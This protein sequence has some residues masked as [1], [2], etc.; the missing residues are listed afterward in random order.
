M[1]KTIQARYTAT[2]VGAVA[3]IA[4]LTAAGIELWVTPSLTATD[5]RSLTGAAAR[6]GDV[7][8]TELARVQAQQRV[9]TETVPQLESA[10]IDRLLP[11][12]VNQYGELKVFGGGIWPLPNKRE[13]G[14]AKFSTF[15][16][17][18][19][20]GKLIVNTHW[21]SPESKNYFEQSWYLGG[22]K[23]PAGQCNWANAYQDD[24]S[25]EP[26]T[27]CAMAISKNGEPYGVATID[28]TLGFFNDL[29]AKKEAELHARLLIVESDGTVL[30]NEPE[31][32]GNNVLKNL[33]SLAGQYPFAA[34][35]QSAL[36]GGLSRDH[37][38]GV[39][40]SDYTLFIQ[41][42]EGTPWQLVVAQ[43]THLLTQQSSKV[44]S[45]LAA[46]Q[47]PLVLVLLAL[48][49]LALRSLIK[50]LRVL[51]QNIDTLSAGDADLT[52]RI[53]IRAD[54]ELGAVGESVNRFIGYLQNMMKEVAQSSVLI[55]QGID[56]LRQQA[57][58][59]NQI[60]TRHANETDQA[61]TAITEMTSTAEDVARNAAQTA[62]MT[63]TA[64]E[65]ARQSKRVVDDASSSVQALI[66]EV[67]AATA[68]VRSM[69]E[70]AQ[71]INAVLGVIGEI[72]G[73]TNLLALNAAIEAA[74]AGEQG[75]GFAVVADEVRALAGRT[76]TSTSEINDMLSRLQQGVEAAVV[77]ME[78]TKQSCQATVDKTARVNQG[79]DGMA[80]SVVQINDLS[81][82]IAT[83]AEEQS[84]VS[85]EINRNMVAVRHMVEELVAGGAQGEQSTAAL[86]ASNERLIAV[87]Q[88]FKLG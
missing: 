28:V 43:Q 50:R 17:R 75:R 45:T 88:R 52:R 15:Y 1:L 26:R 51:K 11:S 68:K 53:A 22:L 3:L 23:A 55:G 77:A 31:M 46:L 37:F 69:E 30:S 16:H 84:A 74:R 80:E 13:P 76:Q 6:I 65:N 35:V 70:D 10:D 82:Q 78:S 21:N 58:G 64:D 42:I 63:R 54:D 9:I 49:V 56:Q 27:N 87:V 12:M 86:A 44:L 62:T 34:A 2:F 47:L 39:D 33:S 5:E 57:K 7:I 18:D 59:T 4:I 61:V 81:S 20:S 40:G 60:L 24:A 41:P 66:G 36:K 67:D 71:R 83:A 73:Q 29:V 32:A 25:P 38:T 8:K 85:E 72:A 19:A 14:R 48:M 79:L